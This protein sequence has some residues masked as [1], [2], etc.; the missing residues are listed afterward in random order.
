[1][2]KTLALDY[3]RRAERQRPEEPDVDPQVR[4]CERGRSRE[5][6]LLDPG[7]RMP[8]DRGCSQNR[9][10][11]YQG[12]RNCTLKGCQTDPCYRHMYVFMCSIKNRLPFIETDR[13]TRLNTI[14]DTC[15][16]RDLPPLQ[17]GISGC[18]ASGGAGSA[19]TFDLLACAPPATVYD[20]FGVAVCERFRLH[21]RNV[22]T[23]RA[24]CVTLN[25]AA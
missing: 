8:A 6:S 18:N 22:Q 15:G 21:T 12:S 17:G 5:R 7:V 24:L 14:R 10:P 3:G 1:M 4:F 20:A 23:P 2:S 19:S 13:G 11:G 16:E 25:S 9:T